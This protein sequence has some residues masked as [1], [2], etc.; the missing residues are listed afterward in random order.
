VDLVAAGGRLYGYVPTTYAARPLDALQADIDT[1]YDPAYWRG[2][3]V[4]VSGISV[5]EMSNDVAHTSYYQPITAYV[6]AKNSRARVF[7][8]PW[9]T[10]VA[11]SSNGT[12]GFTAEDYVRAVDTL[13]TNENTGSTYRTAYAAPTFGASVDASHFA[14]IVHSETA[15]AD[16]RTDLALART[17]KAG[18]VY[19]TDDIGG[20]MQNGYDVLPSYWSD[21]LALFSAAHV[22]A[23]GQGGA[24]AALLALLYAGS[25]SLTR[26]RSSSAASRSSCQPM[27]LP[28]RS[29]ARRSFSNCASSSSRPAFAADKRRVSS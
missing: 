14:H 1:Y 16:M 24:L 27:A 26:A 12:S 2:A 13:V 10:S 3:G 6:R 17:R 19:V 9:T 5:D 23:L 18:Y 29:S 11:D 7:G 21:E 22:P 20:V 15:D 8:N 25:S 4:L 28:Q